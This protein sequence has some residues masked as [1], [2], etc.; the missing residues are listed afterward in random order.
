[1]NI[2][3][4]SIELFALYFLR[5]HNSGYSQAKTKMKY[6]C[7]SRIWR[8]EDENYKNNQYIQII[9]ELHVKTK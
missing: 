5:T 9:V 4:F 1:M 3:F 7:M 2:R 6:F 8:L